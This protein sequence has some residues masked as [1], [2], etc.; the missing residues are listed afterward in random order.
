M[1]KNDATAKWEPEYETDENGE[2]IYYTDSHFKVANMEN[3]KKYLLR[4]KVAYIA[5]VKRG[6]KYLN[7]V[8]MEEFEFSYD[9]FEKQEHAGISFNPEWE[10]D[11]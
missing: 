7:L 3:E 10:F 11:L 4:D 9:N 2:Y 8:S 5:A 1:K 6:D